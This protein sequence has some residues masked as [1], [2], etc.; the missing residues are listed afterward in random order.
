MPQID[1]LVEILHNLHRPHLERALQLYNSIEA[2]EGMADAYWDHLQENSP[3]LA[4]ELN[5]EQQRALKP[6]LNALYGVFYLLN[7]CSINFPFGRALPLLA[8]VAE[9]AP[10][11]LAQETLFDKMKDEF[12]VASHSDDEN[13]ENVYQHRLLMIRSMLQ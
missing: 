8:F 10:V 13:A 12:A 9:A 3:A 2:P 1:Q 6:A 11:R 7:H 4:A 5:P